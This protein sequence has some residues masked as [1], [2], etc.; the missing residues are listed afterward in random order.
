M[1]SLFPDPEGSGDGAVGHHYPRPPGWHGPCSLYTTSVVVRPAS[2]GFGA[3]SP[4]VRMDTPDAV[5]SVPPI[6]RLPEITWPRRAGPP[7]ASL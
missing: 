1:Q 6:L 2:P 3:T 4:T 5:G 7:G